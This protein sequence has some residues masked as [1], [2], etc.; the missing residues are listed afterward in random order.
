[1]GGRGGGGG[2]VVDCCGWP[3]GG[4]PRPL[5]I[6]FPGLPPPL[7]RKAELVVQWLDL[8]T[9]IPR[10]V[11]STLGGRAPRRSGL[12]PWACPGPALH[13]GPSGRDV[14]G[15]EECRAAGAAVKRRLDL[16]GTTGMDIMPPPPPDDERTNTECRPTKVQCSHSPGSLLSETQDEAL[17]VG[18]C[19]NQKNNVNSV[20][21][22][23]FDAFS[24]NAF[25][26]S[27]SLSHVTNWRTGCCSRMTHATMRHTC[28]AKGS[29]KL[30]FHHCHFVI[31]G[32][33]SPPPPTPTRI[34]VAVLYS[35][36][37]HD[38]NG[39]A[40][41]TS[42]QTSRGDLHAFDGWRSRGPR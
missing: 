12:V 6:P 38:R 8:Y 40:S 33:M 5:W 27:L 16:G 34:I 17:D 10:V 3:I 36:L 26:F 20:L 23:L 32:V 21:Q 4:P 18:H 28:K 1:M 37:G 31:S 35:S 42:A 7:V 15:K 14:M 30:Q 13:L 39:A 2:Q 41:H 19:C 29:E 22:V 11:R 9:L 25:H 24:Q